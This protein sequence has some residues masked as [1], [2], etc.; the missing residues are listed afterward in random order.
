MSGKCPRKPVRFF[1]NIEPHIVGHITLITN[2]SVPLNL[3]ALYTLHICYCDI[4]WQYENFH[5]T[6]RVRLGYND[7]F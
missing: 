1:V 7:E 4:K 2:P 5:E 6:T 3:T